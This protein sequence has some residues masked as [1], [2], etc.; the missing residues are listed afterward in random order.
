MTH[1]GY[2]DIPEQDKEA[3]VYE[4]F[5]N[6][7]EKYDVMNDAMSFGI[8]RL[9][10]DHFIADL[11]PYPGIRVLDV[12]GGTGDIAFRIIKWIDNVKNP[13]DISS[14]NVSE[15]DIGGL[16]SRREATSGGADTTPLEEVVCCDLNLRMLEVG[17]HRAAQYEIDDR[18]KWVEGNAEAL[19][20]PDASFD[21]YTIAFG[22][23]NCT[24]VDQVLKEAFRVLRRGGRFMCLE[25]SEVQNPLLRWVYDQYSMQV[26]PVLG[27]VIA[28]DWDSY[29]YLVESI[30]KFPNQE[31][32]LQMIYREGFSMARYEN[33]TN[34][35]VAIHSG[36][37]F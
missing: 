23:R 31:E 24:H 19:P 15:I 25:F 28:Q 11:Q 8:H 36:F 6:V 9:W 4:V 10:K 14:L 33:L 12:A 37:K 18:V 21:A 5:H 20:F 1:F 32:F 29:Q 7:A 17:E 16:S 22:I 13:G 27:Q 2:E 26:I 30:R 35:I 34:G 3:R